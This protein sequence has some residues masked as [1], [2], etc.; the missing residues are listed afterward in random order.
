MV[1]EPARSVRLLIC[2]D[3]PV[4]RSGLRGVFAAAADLEV[5]GEASDGAEAV[6]LSHQ[7][8]PDVALMDLRMPKMGGAEAIRKIKARQPEVQVLVLTTYDT[9]ADVIRAIEEGATGFLLKDTP[10]EE[11]LRAVRDVSEGRSP[12]APGA[13]S[14]LVRQMRSGEEGLSPREIEILRLVAE[15]TS[16]KDIAKELWISEAT[17]KGHMTRIL[18]KLGAPDRT[19]AV[20]YALRRGIIRLDP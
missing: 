19:A 8:A 20:T 1:T 6:A 3:H 18:E 12:L 5:V 7:L 10:P 4:V 14:R 9:D 16:N 2:D 15:G 17:V 11:L 13:A